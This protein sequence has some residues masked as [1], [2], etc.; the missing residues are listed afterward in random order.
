MAIE[1][2]NDVNRG[3]AAQPARA[4]SEA[5][6]TEAPRAS[7]DRLEVSPESRG[8]APLSAQVLEFPEVRSERVD[9][10]R[11]RIAAGRYRIGGRQLAAALIRNDAVL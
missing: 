10:V 11:E 3:S 4:R 8:I 9:A 2:S 6:P 1:R 7:S 5:T